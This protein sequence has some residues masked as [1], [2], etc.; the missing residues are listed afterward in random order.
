MLVFGPNFAARS[1]YLDRTIAVVEISIR[2]IPTMSLGVSC[3]YRY[4]PKSVPYC[5]HPKSVPYRYHPKPCLDP[6]GNF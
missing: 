3:P 2:V 6:E 5:Y 4:H 1:G